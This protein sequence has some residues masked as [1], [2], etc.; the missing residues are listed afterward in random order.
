MAL[1][2]PKGEQSVS[3]A[4]D[5]STVAQWGGVIL[6]V[7]AVGFSLYQD[8][9]ISKVSTDVKTM[10]DTLKQQ[11]QK[12][13]LLETEIITLKNENNSLRQK[14]SSHNRNLSKTS[15][16]LTSV[17]KE[18]KKNGAKIPTIKEKHKH[19]TDDSDSDS[20]DLASDI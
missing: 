3:N 6:G 13:Q 5:I 18:M 4:M 1:Q 14:V 11:Q 8:S 19:R 2:K 7:A 16:I 10:G 20:D 12:I 9:S 15:K 17:T